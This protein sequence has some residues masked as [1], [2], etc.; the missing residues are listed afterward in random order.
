MKLPR[1]FTAELVARH[2]VTGFYRPQK[3]GACF[4][5]GGNTVSIRP[6]TGEGAFFGDLKQRKPVAGRIVFGGGL[7]GGG[8]HSFQ[9]QIIAGTGLLL[10]GVY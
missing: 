2:A 5:V 3:I 6:G 1:A 9:V 8:F 10:R 7:P 4:Y